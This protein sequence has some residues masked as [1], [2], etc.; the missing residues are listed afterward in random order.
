[1][2]G[3]LTARQQTLAPIAGFTAAAFVSL[4]ADMIVNDRRVRMP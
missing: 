2:T 1:M 4:L 3:G